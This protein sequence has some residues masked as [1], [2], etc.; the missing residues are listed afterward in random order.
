MDDA[1]IAFAAVVEVQPDHVKALFLLGM[2]EY[3]LGDITSSK[4]HLTRFLEL[5]PDD[6]D[7]V[8]V[9]EILQ[10]AAQ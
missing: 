4:K 1:A 7:A 6:P 5:A 2:A 9:N 10:Y 3:N 8:I